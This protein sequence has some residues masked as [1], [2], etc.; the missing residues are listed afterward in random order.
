MGER[1]GA[2]MVLVGKP[3]GKRP[4]EDPDINGRIILKWIFKKWDGGG[5]DWIDP[6]QTK[7]RRQALVNAVMNLQVPYYAV[8]FLTS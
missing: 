7:D 8:N 2:Y 4:L 5:M 3:G 6:A 1:R